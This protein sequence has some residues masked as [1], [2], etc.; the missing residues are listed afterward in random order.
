MCGINHP[1]I[2]TRI[3]AAMP[4]KNLHVNKSKDSLLMNRELHQTSYG[5]F[6][7]VVRLD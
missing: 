7:F 5:L 3:D 1:D 6:I 2:Y 4:N